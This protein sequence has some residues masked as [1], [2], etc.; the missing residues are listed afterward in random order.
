MFKRILVAAAALLLPSLVLAEMSQE[1]AME[2]LRAAEEYSKQEAE[3]EK[4]WLKEWESVYYV[5]T[6]RNGNQTLDINQTRWGGFKLAGQAW[7]SA[8]VKMHDSGL[9]AYRAIDN[10]TYDPTGLIVFMSPTGE[11]YMAQYEL[12]D[13]GSADN[14][15][16]LGQWLCVI[17]DRAE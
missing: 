6:D 17:R 4:E 15:K 12:G 1:E 7:Q 3:R 2:A 10:E 16:V 5:C 14:P 8:P 11:T 9:K 13:N